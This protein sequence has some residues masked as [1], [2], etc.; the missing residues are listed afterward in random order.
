M[1]SV[2]AVCRRSELRAGAIHPERKLI[3][4][5]AALMGFKARLNRRQSAASTSWAT[6]L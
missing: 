6:S 5:R 3:H 2:G 4:V 1:L